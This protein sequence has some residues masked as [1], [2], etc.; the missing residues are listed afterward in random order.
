MKASLCRAVTCTILLISSAA[1]AQTSLSFWNQ[2]D[3]TVKRFSETVVKTFEAAKPGTKVSLEVIP[4]E[5][6]KTAIQVAMSADKQPDVFFNWNGD[7]SGRFVRDGK[8]M[9]IG[10]LGNGRWNGV[11]AANLL[12]S[13]TIDG[14]LYGVPISRHTAYFFYNKAFFDTHKLA[15]AKTTA[16]LRA[17]CKEI[18]RL[19]PKAIPI[20][21]GAKEPWTINHY[22]SMLFARTVPAAVRETDYALKNAADALFADP[23]YQQA[24]EELVAMKTDGC[25]NDGV[26]SVSPEEARSIFASEL[27]VMTYCGTFCV[28]PL[29]KEGFSGKYT[30]FRMPAVAGAKGDPDATFYV[31][32]GLQIAANT[33]NK[34]AAADL[35]NHYVGPDMQAEMVKQLGRLPVNPAAMAKVGEIDPMIRWSIDDLNSAGAPISPLDVELEANVS[36][37][38]LT[39]GQEIMNGTKTPAQL[40]SDVRASA[41]DA[42]IRLGR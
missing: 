5:P 36:K 29:V 18:R 40:M 14:K 16:E 21:L 26:N 9:D 42:K 10:E 31:L 1:S 8:V 25:F 32:T 12:Q 19:D 13:Y 30:A 37:V 39:G 24:L 3:A 41:R 7:A 4:N 27:A 28:G 2:G 15:P 6:F 38:L 20:V 11:V 35:I 33:K 34:E 17:L 22:V 23:G